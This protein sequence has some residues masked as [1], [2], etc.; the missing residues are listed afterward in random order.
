MSPFGG[1]GRQ[2]EV[3]CHLSAPVKLWRKSARKWGN[4][5]DSS[6]F[7]TPTNAGRAPEHCQ[8]PNAALW[9]LQ[10]FTWPDLLPLSLL[11]PF[12]PLL[13]FLVFTTPQFSS[14][15]RLW[16]CSLCQ[17][18]SHPDMRGPALQWSVCLNVTNPE[19]PP[20]LPSSLLTRPFLFM[21]YYCLV[22]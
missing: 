20:L 4:I 2:P 18:H 13:I 1:K 19:R 7:L 14:Y 5:L 17:Q 16:R 15:L 6:W 8:S 11:T 22:L 10:C 12:V 21:M 9:E 3:L